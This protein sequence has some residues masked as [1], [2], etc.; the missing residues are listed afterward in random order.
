MAFSKPRLG[1]ALESDKEDEEIS[2]DFS[3]IKNIFKRKKEGEKETKKEE[4]A[5][6]GK[7]DSKEEDEEID[8]DFG[9]IKSIFN[10]LRIR[11][12]SCRNH[13]FKIKDLSEKRL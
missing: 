8:I 7:D 11:N 12:L 6:T 1:M 13:L 4:A 9:R 10:P 5:E 2:I 3:K